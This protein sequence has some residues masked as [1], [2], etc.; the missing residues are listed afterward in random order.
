MKITKGEVT[1]EI[2][3]GDDPY[4]VARYLEAVDV[5]GR[6]AMITPGDPSVL[7]RK[8]REV[9][10]VLVKHDDGA[11]YTA[12]AEELDLPANIVNSRLADLHRNYPRLVQ[13]VR[14]GVYTVPRG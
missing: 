8:Q 1:V 12:I 11:H 10:D 14:W 4:E 13:R 9:Y 6:P 7:T 3:P 2:E 5:Y